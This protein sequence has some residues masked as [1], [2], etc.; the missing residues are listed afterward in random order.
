MR[1][2]GFSEKFGRNVVFSERLGNA[3][4]RAD[5][6]AGGCRAGPAYPR[7]HRGLLSQQADADGATDGEEAA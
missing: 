2:V 7:D 3:R 1:N 5:Q 6:R 4:Q